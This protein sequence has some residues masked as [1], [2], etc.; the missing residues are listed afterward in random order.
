MPQKT[1]LFDLVHN[2]MLNID[3]GEFSEF[4]N[5]LKRMDLKIKKTEN[6]HLKKNMLSDVD[7]LIIGNPIDDYFSSLEV[8]LIIDFVRIGGGLLILSEYG[9]D[10]LQKTNL[11]DI[12]GKFGITFDKNIIK[13]INQANQNC[14]SILHIKD[15]LKHQI[16]RHIREITIGGACSL[17]LSKNSRPIFRIDKLIYCQFPQHH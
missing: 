2:E 3:D 4:L 6:E 11:N 5:L 1:V 8:K 14:S 16:T 12:C 10:S 9:A 15:F 13:E 17:I 7:L